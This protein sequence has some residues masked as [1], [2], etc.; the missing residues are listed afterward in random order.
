M[1]Q[2]RNRDLGVFGNALLCVFTV[3]I[4]GA[5]GDATFAQRPKATIEE[6]PPFTEY[7]GVTIGMKADDA[8]KKL[9]KPTEKDEV[10]DFYI[11]S[12]NETA[13][14]FYDKAQMVVAFS[15]NFVGEGTGVPKAKAVLGADAKVKPDG[16]IHELIRFPK[17]GYWISYSRTAGDSP[18]I[19]I[20]LQKL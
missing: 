16:S 9:G 10:Q 19:T 12:D 18:T 17:A 11:V 8:R 2:T 7:K 3:F 6:K 15:V 14:V 13:Q 5:A 4:L 20:T 1:Y